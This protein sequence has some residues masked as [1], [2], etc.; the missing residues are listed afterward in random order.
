LQK[1]VRFYRTAF[2]LCRLIIKM[3]ASG[4]DSRESGSDTHRVAERK[5]CGAIL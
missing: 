1:A 3:D 5:N 2:F 4:A